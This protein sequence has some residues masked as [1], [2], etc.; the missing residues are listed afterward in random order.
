MS[1][2]M[3]IRAV[4]AFVRDVDSRRSPLTAQGMR[5]GAEFAWEFAESAGYGSGAFGD[6]V[7]QAKEEGAS[8]D[9]WIAA[10]LAAF[11]ALAV[12]GEMRRV[13]AGRAR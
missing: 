3:L 7:R 9:E 5:H 6:A 10:C 4:S 12:E 8:R 11:D 1:G 13:V 2:S